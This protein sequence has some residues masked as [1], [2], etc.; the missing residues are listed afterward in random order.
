MRMDTMP[1]Q[2]VPTPPRSLADEAKLSLSEAAVC[3][4]VDYDT[5]LAWVRKGA[6][7]HV[8]VGPFNRKMV[9]RRVVESLIRHGK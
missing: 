1:S 5:F 2:D 9:L 6:V 3:C 7:P 4:G 8:V